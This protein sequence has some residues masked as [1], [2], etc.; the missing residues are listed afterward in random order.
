MITKCIT[1]KN[2][3]VQCG[4]GIGIRRS[5]QQGRIHINPRYQRIPNNTIVQPPLFSTSRDVLVVMVPDDRPSTSP[6]APK[7]NRQIHEVFGCIVAPQFVAH[8]PIAKENNYKI[9]DIASRYKGEKQ[10]IRNAYRQLTY[11]VIFFPKCTCN[12]Q[13]MCFL[14]NNNAEMLSW[15]GEMHGY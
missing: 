4:G 14:S 13:I 2:L 7:Q 6:H 12:G 1:Y 11:I 5:I 9:K 3:E 15:N 8:G 10:E